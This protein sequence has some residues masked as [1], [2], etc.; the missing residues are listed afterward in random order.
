MEDVQVATEEVLAKIRWEDR[1]RDERDG[2]QWTPEY[3]IQKTL[4]TTVYEEEN[5]VLD[6]RKKRVTDLK[7]NRR[8]IIPEPSENIINNTP[9]EV[10][11]ANMKTRI[12][13]FVQTNMK[14]KCDPRGYP[15]TSNLSSTEAEGLKSLRDRDDVFVTATDKTKKLCINTRENYTNRMGVHLTGNQE[16]NWAA[17]QDNERVL[18]A[19]AIQMIRMF[20]IG[21]SSI[22]G[23]GKNGVS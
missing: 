22:S 20:K 23:Q 10:G 21:Q 3:Q 7:T 16:I 12:D 19:H 17:K 14:Q 15:R 13:N 8:I 18:N 2:E 5:G 11:M 9:I 6:F 1:S 4:L